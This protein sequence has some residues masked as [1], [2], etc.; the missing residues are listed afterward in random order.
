MALAGRG[1]LPISTSAKP[2]PNPIAGSWLLSGKF[3]RATPCAWR[4]LPNPLLVPATSKEG[5]VSCE[6][7]LTV[8]VA[9]PSTTNVDILEFLLPLAARQ[10]QW[11]LGMRTCPRNA[12]KYKSSAHAS[13]RGVASWHS[14]PCPHDLRSSRAVFVETSMHH[15]NISGE[16]LQPPTA[17]GPDSVLHCPCTERCTD[18]MSRR[19]AVLF[20]FGRH[21]V[22]KPLRASLRCMHMQS[23]VGKF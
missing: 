13:K 12:N 18:R 1:N 23:L 19:S 21:L 16:R 5:V 10:S 7:S 14:R 3:R 11:S 8:A 22:S 9:I 2:L 4:S 17:S 15:R 6:V 20:G